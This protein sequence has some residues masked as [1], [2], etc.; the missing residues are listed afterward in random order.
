MK[1]STHNKHKVNIKYIRLI[2]Q[3]IGRESEVVE[4]IL[5]CSPV[6]TFMYRLFSVRFSRVLSPIYREGYPILAIHSQ[7]IPIHS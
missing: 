3:R 7:I 5:T 2:T 1:F 4:R 6:P